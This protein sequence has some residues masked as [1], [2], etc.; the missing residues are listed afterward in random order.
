MMMYCLLR[1]CK[2]D[3][4]NIHGY[5]SN[6]KIYGY[7]YIYLFIDILIFGVKSFSDCSCI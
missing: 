4:E 3:V 1:G 5:I 2:K 7:I 6:L